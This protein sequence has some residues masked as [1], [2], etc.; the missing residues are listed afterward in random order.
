M[1]GLI[2]CVQVMQATCLQGS[3]LARGLSV[4]GGQLREFAPASTHRLPEEVWRSPEPVEGREA[5]DLLA[6]PVA[7]GPIGRLMVGSSP[8]G[9][10]ISIDGVDTGRHTPVL[11]SAPIELATGWHT[12]FVELAGRRSATAQFKIVE[13]ERS[14]IKLT[15]E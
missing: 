3:D 6:E 11:P 2:L 4:R 15:I 13:G 14:V 8:T 10:R 12:I 9:A 5:R 1:R 7:H